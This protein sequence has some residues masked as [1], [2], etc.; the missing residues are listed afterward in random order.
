LHFYV[1]FPLFR[2]VTA[3]LAFVDDVMVAVVV[4][5]VVDVVIIGIVLCFFFVFFSLFI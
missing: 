1:N 2:S 5:V 3:L 4:V